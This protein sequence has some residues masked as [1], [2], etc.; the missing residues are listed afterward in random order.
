MTL[1]KKKVVILAGD[2]NTVYWFRRELISDFQKIDYE[3]HVI[4]PDI[5]EEF[6]KT[7]HSMEVK[8]SKLVLKRKTINFLD[9]FTSFLSI[10]R[11]LESISPDILIAYTLK[12]VFLSGLCLYFLNIQ[13]S[14]AL[15]TGTGHIFHNKSSLGKLKKLLVRAA[16]K[17]SM[18]SYRLVFFQN[19]DDRNIFLKYQ[20]VQSN[21]IRMMNGSGVNL[22]IFRQVDLVKNPVFLCISR[23]IKSK[24]LFEYAEAAKLVKSSHPRAQFLLFGYPDEH[25]DS[26]DEEEIIHSWGD[27]YGIEYHGFSLT[28]EKTIALASV[29]VLLSHHEGTPRV[30]LEAMAMG[31]PIVT[32]N[33][34]GCKE[35]VEEGVNGF[36]VPVG[37]SKAAASQMIKLMNSDLRTSMGN[38]SRKIAE[39]KFDVK[40]VNKNLI[41]E[42]CCH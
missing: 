33:A 29:F 21:Q 22:E 39:D 38:A 9:S 24:G 4:A 30:V 11:I 5:K 36:K 19:P 37:D 12:S 23:L 40:K 27:R 17:M 35:T 20:I 15:I 18:P 13:N 16:L 34:P 3:V 8:F 6:L 1:L 26:I 14:T 2:G 25:S 10:K 7:F 28:P 42:I 32:T 41:K 31:R